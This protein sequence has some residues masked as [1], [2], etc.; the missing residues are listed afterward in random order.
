VSKLSRLVRRLDWIVRR[1]ELENTP[2]QSWTI[3][4]NPGGAIKGE[5]FHR[6]TL[7]M[8]RVR[9]RT[10]GIALK[11]VEPNP[12]T[13]E[14]CELDV[15]RAMLLR[16]LLEPTRMVLRVLGKYP[17]LSLDAMMRNRKALSDW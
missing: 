10:S 12:K 15:G 6:Y 4:G 13:I 8:E 2:L 17:G 3:F 5:A 14:R 16:V 11:I 7:R 1:A 9:T